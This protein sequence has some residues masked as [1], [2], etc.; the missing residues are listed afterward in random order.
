MTIWEKILILTV[1]WKFCISKLQSK[2]MLQ[3]KLNIF[4]KLLFFPNS[5]LHSQ[6]IVAPASFLP[7]S[8]IRINVFKSDCFV[9]LLFIYF[10]FYFLAQVCSHPSDFLVSDSVDPPLS[11]DTSFY[12]H[13][14][15][16]LPSPIFLC[17][18]LDD[19]VCETQS[20]SAQSFSGYFSRKAFTNGP[21]LTI[22]CDRILGL[23]I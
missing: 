16:H 2:I 23:M 10:L 19:E 7:V 18:V 17:D 20:F 3:D 9:L 21:K 22:I 8:L 14:F 5:R 1:L 4:F 11:S 15:S 6:I 12:T 13:S